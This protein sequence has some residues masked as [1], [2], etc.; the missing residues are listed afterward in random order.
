MAGLLFYMQEAG[1]PGVAADPAVDRTAGFGLDAD[2]PWRCQA[3]AQAAV[4]GVWDDSSFH[5]SCGSGPSYF[6]DI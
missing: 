1:S 5:S 6:Y 3:L 2:A 4:C